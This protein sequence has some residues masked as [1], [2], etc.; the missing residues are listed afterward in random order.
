[1]NIDKL[2]RFI[3]D[4]LAARGRSKDRSTKV[5]AVALDKD[6]VPSHPGIMVSLVV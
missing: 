2:K 5:G 6:F 4:A 3:P 1:M